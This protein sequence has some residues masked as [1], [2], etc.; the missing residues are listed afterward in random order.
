MQILEEVD[1]GLSGAPCAC[2]S[3]DH[4]NKL[5]LARLGTVGWGRPLRVGHAEEVEHERQALGE[6]LVE[7]QHPPGDLLACGFVAIL[8]GNSEEGAEELQDREE[9]DKL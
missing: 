9:G 1:G 8:L 6:R 5:S 7:Q 4:V 2:K 3:P